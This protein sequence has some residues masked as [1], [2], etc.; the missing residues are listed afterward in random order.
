MSGYRR[1]SSPFVVPSDA[2][3]PVSRPGAKTKATLP[4]QPDTGRAGSAYGVVQAAATL[5][6]MLAGAALGQ[7]IG[8]GATMNLAALAVGGSAATALLI[9]RGGPAAGEGGG[10]G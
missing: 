8:I 1:T 9:P 6:G 2:A 4:P 7:R 10:G 3:P 5:V